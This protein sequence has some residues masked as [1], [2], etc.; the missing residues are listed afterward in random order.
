MSLRGHQWVKYCTSG[1]H[2]AASR[3]INCGLK[4]SED[5]VQP[6]LLQRYVVEM[7]TLVHTS[8]E[9]PATC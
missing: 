7:H 9:N 4:D 5:T 3:V 1:V 2:K 8:L 6:S